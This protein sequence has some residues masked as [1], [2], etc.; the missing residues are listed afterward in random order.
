MYKYLPFLLILISLNFTGIAQIK[1]TIDEKE[2]F[3]TLN[4]LASDSLKG[5]GN[6]SPELE[7]LLILFLQ[8]LRKQV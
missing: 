7:K 3:Q 8:N 1:D 6:F 5:R 4:F 2:V